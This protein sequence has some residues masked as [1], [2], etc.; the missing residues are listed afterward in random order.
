M[1]NSKHI[2]EEGESTTE[3]WLRGQ[4]NKLF[5]KPALHGIFQQIL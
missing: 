1:K 3:S 2:L 4:E 5:A